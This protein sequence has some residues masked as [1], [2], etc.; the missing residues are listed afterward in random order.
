MSELVKVMPA[1]NDDQVV[2]WEVHPDHPDGEIWIVGDG[3][4]Y[5]VA[6][7]HRVR[8]RI[9][10]GQLIRLQS[11]D[12]ADEVLAT[13]DA[14][15]DS[16]ESVTEPFMGYDSMTAAQIVATIATLDDDQ[17]SAVLAYE[18]AHENRKTVL[19]ALG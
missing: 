7:T 3:T 4:S 12:V 9:N 5:L 10:E 2:L 11:V 8:Q 17:R 14:T 19:K 1:R 6:L 13:T 15:E 16:T 18:S